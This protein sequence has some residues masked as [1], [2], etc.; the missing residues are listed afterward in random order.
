MNT[1]ESHGLSFTVAAPDH[2]LSEVH[3]TE[4][5]MQDGT[6]AVTVR[7]RTPLSYNS[8]LR[9]LLVRRH[10]M[11]DDVTVWAW[12]SLT[13]AVTLSV[14][15]PPAITST[16]RVAG[17]RVRRERRVPPLYHVHPRLAVSLLER[18]VEAGA[19]SDDDPDRTLAIVRECALCAIDT[20]S[21]DPATLPWKQVAVD[22]AVDWAMDSIGYEFDTCDSDVEEF[23]TR[24]G[25]NVRSVDIIAKPEYS[26]V[27]L[28]GA[29]GWALAFIR[30]LSQLDPESQTTQYYQQAVRA[31]QAAI[32]QPQV[33]LAMLVPDVHRW[34]EDC[35]IVF[36]RGGSAT[37][38][39]EFP[40][41]MPEE[42]EPL[43]GAVVGPA[44]VKAVEELL[45]H[46]GTAYKDTYEWVTS[47][48]YAW[49]CY[50]HSFDEKWLWGYIANKFDI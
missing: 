38:E 2:D 25:L 50:N 10:P 43:V 21:A 26:T 39:L 40:R 12:A 5:D 30:A 32:Q 46:V 47:G 20:P 6:Y 27:K 23:L 44:V 9:C 31:A 16:L 34:L 28:R 13:L 37:P 41:D 35:E 14:G 1:I 18:A 3:M 4:A 33:Q 45:D 19:L 48:E 24:A 15:A 22:R 7:V 17:R 8:P 49:E 36:P 42:L 11:R 29:C